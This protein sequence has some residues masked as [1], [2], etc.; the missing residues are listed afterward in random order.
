MKQF[1]RLGLGISGIALALA[2]VAFYFRW[3]VVAHIWP[4]PGD[5]YTP[6]MSPLSFYFLSSIAAAVA[7]PLLWIV[8]TN[9]LHAAVPGAIDLLVTFTGLTVFMVQSYAADSANSNLLIS[10]VVMGGG[11]VFS[12]VVLFSGRNVPLH[13]ARP[14]PLLV[15]LSFYLFI[16]ALTVVGGAMVLKIPNIMPWTL[17]IEAQIV[18]GWAFLGAAVYFLFAV[19]NPRWENAAGQLIGF[20]AYDVVLILPFIRHFSDV[21]PQH[22]LS[23]I[24][25]TAVVV[26]SALIA[27]YFLFLHKPT[28]VFG[29]DD[30]GVP[31]R[32]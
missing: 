19:L 22:R 23:L 8:L 26:Y 18:Y 27:I 5:A 1:I 25:Y 14:L 15:R 24:I 30:K 20:L 32:V 12:A 7:A 11:A 16:L 29:G 21:L 6:S 9:K 28:R 4:W 2:A 17:S 10:A 31:M 13:D 3:P